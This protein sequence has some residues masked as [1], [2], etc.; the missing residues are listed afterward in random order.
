MNFKGVFT[1]LITPFCDGELDSE[2]LRQNIRH[3]I[4]GGVDGILALGTTG[5]APT[6]T[7][8]EKKCVIEIS[9]EEAKGKVPVMVG[10]GSYSTKVTIESTQQA[11]D[12]GAN[13]ALIVTPYYNKPT[14]EGLFQHFEAVSHSV[15]IP[16]VVYNI[17]GRTGQ[18]IETK[19]LKRIASLP[20]VIGVKEASGNIQQVGDVYATLAKDSQDFVLYS[21][22][23]ALTIPLMALGGHGVISVLSNLLPNEVVTMTRF[24]AAGDFASA[25]KIHYRLLPLLRVLFIET[26]PTPIKEAMALCGLAAGGTRL[27]LC[28]MLPENLEILKSVLCDLQLLTR[29][30]SY[31][32]V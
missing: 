9:I 16:I 7:A 23:D 28:S 11:K 5:E 14:Q 4:H 1:A 30:E 29:K 6:L 18:N 19:T 13:A 26:N 24:A 17:Q 12:M 21:G 25:R 10:T 2:G 8:D 3:Q 32:Q 27:P 15:D 20:N 22:D 31:A